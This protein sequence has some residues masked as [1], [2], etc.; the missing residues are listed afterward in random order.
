MS[1]NDEQIVELQK[2]LPDVRI[3]SKK[4]RTPWGYDK[5]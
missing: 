4:M 1:V 2:A 5:Y 3:T